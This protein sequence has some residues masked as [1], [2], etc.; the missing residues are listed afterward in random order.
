MARLYGSEC[1]AYRF[2]CLIFA[3]A[4]FAIVQPGQRWG[5]RPGSR[6][7]PLR[8]STPTPSS[9]RLARP[10]GPAAPW[11]SRLGV[12][13]PDI[14][15]M[16]D[17]LWE[18]ICVTLCSQKVTLLKPSSCYLI[19]SWSLLGNMSMEAS[20]LV[21]GVRSCYQIINRSIG[22]V[23]VNYQLTTCSFNEQW[24]LFERTS[25][26]LNEQLVVH[27]NGW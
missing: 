25:C 20:A 16:W 6:R 14:N 19:H 8:R 24:L 22:S 15:V 2:L 26:S 5:R 10:Q 12:R 17:C 4:E 18:D 27:L 23:Q 1:L 3:L 9:P 13:W 21:Q 11:S 7:S